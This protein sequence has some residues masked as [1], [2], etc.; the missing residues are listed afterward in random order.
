MDHH[1]EYFA[2]LGAQLQA[3]IDAAGM[4][5]PPVT[6][7]HPWLTDG[8]YGQVIRN[9]HEALAAREPIAF[10]DCVY[11]FSEAEGQYVIRLREG[12]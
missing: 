3:E 5:R 4:G 12:G 10:A 11:E 9:V 6:G 1:V 7:P 2:R 8:Q